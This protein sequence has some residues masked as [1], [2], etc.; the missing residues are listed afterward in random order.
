MAATTPA[1]EHAHIRFRRALLLVVAVAAATG[2]L[3]GLSRVGVVLG[4]GPTFAADHG[5][6]L[7]VGVFG[8]V[9]ALERAVALGSRWGYSAAAIGAA[10]AIGMLLGLASAGW[11]GV[12]TSAALVVVNAAIIRRQSAAFTWLMFLGA[13]V[14]VFGNVFWTLGHPVRNVA[15]AWMTF[16]V[17]TIAAERLELSRLAP[18]PMWAKVI[19]VLC[20]AALAVSASLVSTGVDGAL[21]A[22]GGLMAAIG[23]WQ[24]RFDLARRTL[25][26]RGL[27]RF[28]AAGVL[29]G[30][31][32]LAF[33][34]STLL[35]LG[36][37]HAGPVYDA[38]LH[39]VFVGY[40]LSMV[41][42]HAPII[43]PAVA[44]VEIPFHPVL[45]GAPVL[46]HLGLLLRVIGDLG[47]SNDLRQLGS[48][49]NAVAL[50]V[51]LMGALCSRLALARS[52][53]QMA[54]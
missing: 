15:P 5:P 8:T 23:L 17:L 45:W 43:L 31:A 3:A 41:L 54:P 38:I 29:L 26:R 28:S 27:P 52:Q 19:L 4:W 42:A 44:R 25:L 35:A 9:I 53:G 21:G 50:V 22:A 51:F 6:M 13:L 2:V 16:F 12:L 14:L 47:T 37:P 1:H 18:T 49:L 20:A 11:L 36:L 34:G 39:G 24:L 46:L 48:V 7:V 40:V 10:A 33:S 30:A 32:W